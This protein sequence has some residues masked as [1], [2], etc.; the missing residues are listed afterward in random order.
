MACI[1]NLKNILESEVSSGHIDKVCSQI[2]D[3]DNVLRSKQFPFRFL[4]AYR[5]LVSS[6]PSFDTGRVLEALELAMIHSAENIPMFDGENVKIA[7]DV[8]GSMCSPISDKSTVQMYDVGI[9]LSMLLQHKCKRVVTG[10]FGTSYLEQ[11]LPKNNILANSMKM[12]SLSSKVGWATNGHLIIE[13]AIKKKQDLDR[14]MIFTDMQIWDNNRISYNHNSVPSIQNLWVTYK[15]MNPK[16]KLIIFDLAGYGTSPLSLRDN[17]VF[18]IAGFS[19][20]V[21]TMLDSIEKGS[22]V[23][24][25]INN[26]II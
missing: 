4:S 16:C 12:G 7:S 15:K 20:K 9:V 14:I 10:I 24:D 23:L 25:V 26:I 18:L 21:F 17:D 2:S 6:K 3:R 8:S 13:D 5:M 1:R 11:T 22:D 19:D